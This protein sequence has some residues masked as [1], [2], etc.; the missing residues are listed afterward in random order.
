MSRQIP[1]IGRQNEMLQIETAIRDEGTRQVLC[2]HGEG[3][4]GKTRLLEEVYKQYASHKET[5]MLIADIIDFDDYALHFV[6]NVELYIAQK[7]GEDGFMS[8][9]REWQER[10]ELE[11]AGVS[12]DLLVKKSERV[13]Q[14]LVNDFNNLSSNRRVV[15][16]FDT[17]DRINPQVW[18]LLMGL[19]LA[20]S[21]VVF[22][23]AGRNAKELWESLHKLGQE[24]KLL[25][26]LPF[27]STTAE[28]Y[29]KRKAD[30]LGVTIGSDLVPKY[31][32]LAEGQ[33][34]LIDLALD[35][36][37]HNHPLDWIVES[38]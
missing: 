20:S 26:L 1:F 16:L 2:I 28:E 30:M 8:F 35:W 34:M 38:G 27:D 33:P 21:N 31:L 32:F 7:L 24:A 5:S 37:S 14:I 4:L 15:L 25:E 19:V 23:L 22:L 3:G 29:L 18:N 17:I 13:D 11:E 9:L 10:Q 12:P 36:A 6:A